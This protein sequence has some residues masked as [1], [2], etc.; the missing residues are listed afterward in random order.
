MHAL[1][2]RESLEVELLAGPRA[3]P[4]GAAPGSL[5]CEREEAVSSTIAGGWTSEADQ[6]LPQ[7]GVDRGALFRRSHARALQN[8]LIDR[9]RE[10]GHGISVTRDQCAV[11]NLSRMFWAQDPEALVVFTLEVARADPG[12]FDEL[13]DWLLVNEKLLSVRRLRAMCAD[14]EDERLLAGALGWLAR[15][16]LAH[17]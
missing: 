15:T 10:I 11:D 8:V 6:L 3:P 2:D 13:L 7:H 5:T 16:G 12:L 14:P 17:D 1:L 9:D 4:A